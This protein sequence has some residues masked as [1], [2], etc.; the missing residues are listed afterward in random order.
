MVGQ[1]CKNSVTKLINKPLFHWSAAY[2]GCHKLIGCSHK[3]GL[4]L[5][6]E[7]P[8]NTMHESLRQV[9]RRPKFAV[10]LALDFLDV[11][12]HVMKLC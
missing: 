3:I 11:S 6:S 7:G 1:N 12:E 4:A 2:T 10:H 9:L 8:L 5:F